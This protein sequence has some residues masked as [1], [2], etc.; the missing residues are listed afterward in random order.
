MR[1][2]TGIPVPP[3]SII[4]PALTEAENS[5]VR[6]PFL[7]FREGKQYSRELVRELSTSTDSKHYIA[8]RAGALREKGPAACA[9]EAPGA[10]ETWRKPAPFSNLGH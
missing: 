8:T 7:G 3:S 4:R 10:P 9:S 6:T 5:K 1:D 2:L